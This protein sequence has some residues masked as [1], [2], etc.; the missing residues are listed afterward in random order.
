[1]T[2]WS[3]TER[4]TK[5][6][7]ARPR[8][9]RPRGA[10]PRGARNREEHDRG[11][12]ETERSTIERSAALLRPRLRQEQALRSRLRSC[13]LNAPRVISMRRSRCAL[14]VP[15]HPR[16]P[17]PLR[18]SRRQNS[19]AGLVRVQHVQLRTSSR[20]TAFLSNTL[21]SSVA[22]RSRHASL[23]PYAGASTGLP[24]WPALVTDSQLS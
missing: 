7:G 22:Q 10:R 13:P 4:S 1:M 19:S 8:G 16:A 14:C 17:V 21:S 2:E 3:T 11:E 12:H 15:L 18:G 6:R 5:P 24:S 20:S 9:A 23:E